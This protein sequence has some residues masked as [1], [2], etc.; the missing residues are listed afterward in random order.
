LFIFSLIARNSLR[1]AKKFNNLPTLLKLA[2]KFN[3]ERT[4]YR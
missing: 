1:S 2:R 3:H 4:N